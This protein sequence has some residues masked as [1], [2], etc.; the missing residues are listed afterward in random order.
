MKQTISKGDFR[1][2]FVGMNRESNF[3]YEGLGALYD[4]LEDHNEDYDLDVVALCCEFSE[5]NILQVLKN[6]NLESIEELKQE[7]AVI[8]H[9]DTGVL[10][11]QF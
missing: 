7:T 3:S 9:D 6:Y 11:Q 4:W 10:Y 8:W 2:A 5:D 1:H